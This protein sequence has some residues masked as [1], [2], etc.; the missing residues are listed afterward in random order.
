MVHTSAFASDRLPARLRNVTK[1]KTALLLACVLASLD[2]WYRTLGSIWVNTVREPKAELFYWI[3]ITLSQTLGTALGDWTADTG[4]LG[5]IGA[6]AIFAALLA[7]LALL[8]YL[9]STSRV[10]PLS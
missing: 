10:L 8:Y 7:V 4:N 9:T 2:V 5:Y 1:G 6:A 3:T